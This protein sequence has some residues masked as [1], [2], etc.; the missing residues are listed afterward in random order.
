M[1]SCGHRRDGDHKLRLRRE[2]LDPHLVEELRQRC[3]GVGLVLGHQQWND[4]VDLEL[5]NHL[6]GPG[7]GQVA[8]EGHACHVD[9]AD[10]LELL[11]GEQVA[12]VAQVDHVQSVEEYD[13]S[14][15]Q[16]ALRASR[17]VACGADAR[18]KDIVDLVLA[19]ALQAKRR[20]EAGR[21]ALLGRGLP[22]VGPTDTR[23]RAGRGGST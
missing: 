6:G 7:R 22:D 11:L 16:A 13:E 21:Y 15:V 19:R 1:V 14:G 20:L 10:L 23:G 4:E 18:H 9:R 12:E 5:G 2:V 3:L 17:L 8:A